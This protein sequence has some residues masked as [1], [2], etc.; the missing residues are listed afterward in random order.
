MTG[1]GLGHGRGRIDSR[2]GAEYP[3]TLSASERKVKTMSLHK[4][5]K[6]K[7]KLKRQRNVLTRGERVVALE[8][9]GTRAD[10]ASVFGL[11][12]VR[13]EV[14]MKKAK[15]KKKKEEEAKEGEAKP[16]EGS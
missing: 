1:H 13:I 2:R 11:P 3:A 10:G 16:A 12:K 7:N 8:K 4:S 14:G 6:S 5:L 9:R 15:A